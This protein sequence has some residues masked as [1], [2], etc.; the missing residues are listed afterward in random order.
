MDPKKGI[1]YLIQVTFHNTHN[2]RL[3]TFPMSHLQLSCIAIN[4]FIVISAR[5]DKKDSRGHRSL[6]LQGRGPEQDGHRRLPRREERFQRGRSQSLRRASR[7]YRPH[8]RSSS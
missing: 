2:L 7:L 6:P 8:S 3:L 1:E 4:Y 5:V